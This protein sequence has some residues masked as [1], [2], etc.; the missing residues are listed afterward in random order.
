VVSDLRRRGLSQAKVAEVM[1]VAQPTVSDD[2]S[3]IK[4]DNGSRVDLR[5]RIPRAEHRKIFERIEQ[6]EPVIHRN[7]RLGLFEGF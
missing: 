2:T 7:P 3:I 4:T 5:V 6:G 1:G